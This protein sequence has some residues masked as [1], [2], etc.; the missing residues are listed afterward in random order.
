K[1]DT[2]FGEGNFLA[3]LAGYEEALAKRDDDDARLGRARALCEL[4]KNWEVSI[5]N[6]ETDVLAR[7]TRTLGVNDLEKVYVRAKADVDLVVRH[8]PDD[9]LALFYAGFLGWRAKGPTAALE[10]KAGVDLL[11]EAGKK[12]DKDW[13]A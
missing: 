2:A 13:R 5:A 9:A 11:V 3:A 6:G 7:I 12:A 4:A 1:G 8:R 10:R